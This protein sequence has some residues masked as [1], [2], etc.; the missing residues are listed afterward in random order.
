MTASPAAVS[1]EFRAL[2]R[3]RARRAPQRARESAEFRLEDPA[4]LSTPPLAT[5]CVPTRVRRRP[6]EGTSC[7]AWSILCPNRHRARRREACTHDRGSAYGENAEDRPGA[8]LDGVGPP[9]PGRQAAPGV[10]SSPRGRNPDRIGRMRVRSARSPGPM[11]TLGGTQGTHPTTDLLTNASDAAGVTCEHTNAPTRT[12][13][14]AAVRGVCVVFCA[15][16]RAAHQKERSRIPKCY[17][18]AGVRLSRSWGTVPARS[19]DQLA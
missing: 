12:R 9:L 1:A 11:V 16:Q 4:E 18:S 5:A 2:W 10:V 15:A 6:G 17:S 3:Q 13:G 7:A 14:R 19:P 8:G